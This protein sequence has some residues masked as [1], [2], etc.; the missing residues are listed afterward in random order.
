[1][2]ACPCCETTMHQNRSQT[3]KKSE[4][5]VKPTRLRNGQH[6]SLF[7]A[8]WRNRSRMIKVSLGITLKNIEN[9]DS[10]SQYLKSKSYISFQHLS[11]F[12][13]AYTTPRCCILP[14]PPP[15][16]GSAPDVEASLASARCQQWTRERL[17]DPGTIGTITR[18]A[19]T[20]LRG[21]DAK[22]SF[23]GQ[24]FPGLEEKSEAW[25]RVAQK[26]ACGSCFCFDVATA[27]VDT[28]LEFLWY[29]MIQ[30]DI[31]ESSWPQKRTKK[32]AKPRW[33]QQL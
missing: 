27:H 28:L 23:L 25:C 13:R 9:T 29:W 3:T 12:T 26:N 20:S 7:W 4:G 2:W 14:P 33:L 24:P 6:R 22:S 18:L 8:A 16:R 11:A 21:S 31:W 10:I 5:N 30:K 32:N 19:T 15:F 1:M 17:F